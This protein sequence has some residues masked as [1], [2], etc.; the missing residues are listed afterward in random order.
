[1]DFLKK[2]NKTPPYTAKLFFMFMMFMWS[3]SVTPLTGFNFSSN[4]VLMPVYLVILAFYFVNYCS[5]SDKPL[6]SFSLILSGWY[7]ISCVKY[8]SAQ[9]IPF[10][11]FYSI[12][13]AHVAFNIF[14]KDEFLRLYEEILVKLCILSLI[15]WAC[16]NLVGSPF[17]KLMHAVAV[18]EN[19]PPT[20]TNSFIVGLGSQF[21][22]GLRRNIGF[23]WEPGRFSCWIILGM[24]VNVIRHKFVCFSFLKNRNFIILF[25]TLITTLSTTGYVLFA[26][27]MIFVLHNRK[28]GLVKIIMIALAVLIIPSIWAM[29]FLSEKISRLSDISSDYETIT[30]F[31][32]VKKMNEVCPQRFTGLYVSFQNFIHDVFWGYNQLDNSY[33]TAVIFRN[34]VR[35]SPSEGIVGI[36]ARF[37][38]FFGMFFYYWLVKSSKL[39]S[40]ALN[41]KGRYFFAI[42]FLGMSFSYGWWDNCI[43]MFFYFSAFYKGSSRYY[44]EGACAK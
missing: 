5:K 38:I 29:P 26:I 40:S 39:L 31:S 27:I 33:T 4:P 11:F 34:T 36:L 3:A 18:Y 24:F 41:Y 19:Q 8:G 16:A 20:E 17:V 10:S 25:A 32:N 43:L 42:L 14:E 15:V 2:R 6:L 1:M 21:E 35:V 44:F 9:K 30:Y 22:M 7:V 28:S 37:G 12:V 23:T 13:I